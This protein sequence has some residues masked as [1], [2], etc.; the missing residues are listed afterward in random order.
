VRR[1]QDIQLTRNR[2]AIFAYSWVAVHQI[3]PGSPLYGETPE[4]M[5]AANAW[6]LVALTGLDE[7]FS[8]TVHAR[9]YYGNRD[10]I[11][12]ARFA[13]IM[14]HNAKGGFSLD[15]SRFDLIESAPMPPWCGDSADPLAIPEESLPKS[16]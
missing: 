2:N 15:F 14:M 16:A 9:K 3:V 4:S 8:Q 6:I 1:F 13:D 12:G 10:I 11:W 7:T 5:A